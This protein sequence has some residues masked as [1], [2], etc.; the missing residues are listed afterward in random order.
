[1]IYFWSQFDAFSKISHGLFPANALLQ[2]ACLDFLSDLVKEISAMVN[3]NQ[4]K[5]FV[6]YVNA[7]LTRC[8]LQ[9]CLLHSLMATVHNMQRND[10]PE[11]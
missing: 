1:M 3:S 7:L 8:K 6:S 2:I 9:K 11:R 4:S 5:A 10:D